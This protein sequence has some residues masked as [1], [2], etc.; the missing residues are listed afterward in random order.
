MAG[1]GN[2]FKSEIC[3]ACGVNPFRTVGTLRPQD[4][5]CLL[6]TSRR[7]LAASAYTGARRTTGSSDAAA[8]LWVYR[9]AGSSCR[10]CGTKILTRKQGLGARSTYWCPDCQKD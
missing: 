6:A 10:R 9:R 8:R 5:E 4:V 3:F 2:V 1:I 7:F